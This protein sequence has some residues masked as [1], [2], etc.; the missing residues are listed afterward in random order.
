MKASRSRGARREL[1]D[2][3][4]P[5]AY[6]TDGNALFSVLDELPEAPSLRLLEDCRTL[7]ILVVHVDDLCGLGVREVHIREAV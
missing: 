1:G 7:E 5:G 2:L 3:L 6:L 4:R